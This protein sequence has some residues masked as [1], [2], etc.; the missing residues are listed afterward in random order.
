MVNWFSILIPVAVNLII[1]AYFFGGMRIE[2]KELKMQVQGLTDARL[3]TLG[4]AGALSVEVREM[5]AARGLVLSNQTLIAV[6][7]QR[8]DVKDKE[9]HLINERFEE[10]FRQLSALTKIVSQFANIT[11]F[12]DK[13]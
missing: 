7:E 1:V 9:I 5:N 13:F 2:L 4:A 11:Q 10:A 8:L 6:L 3:A 12:K